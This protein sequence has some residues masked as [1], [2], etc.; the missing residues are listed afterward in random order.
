MSPPSGKPRGIEAENHSEGSEKHCRLLPNTRCS[1]FERSW[2]TKLTC[3]VSQAE[4]ILSIFEIHISEFVIHVWG[5]NS[6]IKSV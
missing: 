3:A 1:V 6:N 4:R 5:N 2:S